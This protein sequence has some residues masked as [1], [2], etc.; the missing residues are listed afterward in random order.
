MLE[1]LESRTLLVA[2]S[3]PISDPTEF[4]A[5]ADFNADGRADAVTTS[6]AAQ[7]L[8]VLLGNGSG[9]F[10]SQTTVQLSV[11]PDHVAAADL[12]GDS[13]LD[14]ITTQFEAG[15]V[16]VMLG[17]GNGSFQSPVYYPAGSGSRAVVPADFDNDGRIDLVTA[18]S[19][20]PTL[21]FLKGNGGG[22]F[23]SPVN[24]ALS[25]I[26][27]DLTAADFNADGKLDLA[28]VDYHKDQLA[29]LYG[30]GNGT[31]QT[32]LLRST[33]AGPASVAAADLNADGRPDLVTSNWLADSFTVVLNSGSSWSSPND[34]ST[35]AGSAPAYIAVADFDADGRADVM[36]ANSGSA[37]VAVF[38]GRNDGTFNPPQNQSL[39][40]A[41]NTNPVPRAIAVADFNANGQPDALITN[42][43]APILSLVSIAA[44][45]PQPEI[46]VLGNG[47]EI[48]D[49]DTTPSAA[50]GTDFGSI[51]QGGA[52]V[53]RTFTVRNDGGAS[54]TLGSLSLPGGYTLI[55]ALAT[56]LAPGAS[57]TFTVRL[58]SGTSG[59]FA[60]DL[61]FATN[62]ANENPFNFRI[63]GSVTAA[64]A[65]SVLWSAYNVDARPMSLRFAFSTDVSASLSSSDLVLRNLT[66]GATVS[67]SAIA[68]AYDRSTNIA[69]FTFPGYANGIVPNGDYQATL[70]ASGVTDSS[71]ARLSADAV[72]SF[73]FLNGDATRDRKVNIR[74]LYV[75][76]MNRGQS[77]RVF[78]QGDFNYDGIVNTA[79]HEILVQNWQRTL[80]TTASGL[81][82]AYAFEESSGNSVQDSSGMGNVGTISGATRTTAGKNGAALVFDGVNDWVTIADSSSLDLTTAMTLQAWVLPTSSTGKQDV[83]I[84]EGVGTEMY[85]L[86][87][88]SDN[89][90]PE[91]N[92]HVNGAN[93]M[94][95]G[96]ALPLNTWSHLAATYDGATLRLF[97]NGALSA[98]LAVA[99]TITTS[100]GAL[101]IGGNSLWGEF[102]AGRID[103]VRIYNRALSV[104]EIQ[105]D[106]NSPV[107]SPAALQTMATDFTAA[108]PE[109]PTRPDLQPS[110]LFSSIGIF[111]D[112]AP[113][114]DNLLP[115]SS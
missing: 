62:D 61:S 100:D 35:G 21:T 64:A 22:G 37:S 93:R 99:G 88:R 82:A 80:N 65:P 46:T 34:V 58:A 49:G 7:K 72:Q 12:N 89:G 57:D 17:N 78:T 63:S 41:I 33:G 70:V 15:T 109:L 27:T 92:V 91:A 10:A 39:I 29:V 2:T 103:D 97:V 14:L 40:D 111:S 59:T 94:A 112:D 38:T 4:V 8:H 66:T 45:N 115:E 52:N 69:T 77:P 102:F 24:T 25:I 85:N 20:Q 104:S 74:D 53:D 18:K 47:I 101:R 3:V 55:E 32:P 114:T 67:S 110:R 5:T 105:A 13:K 86:Y 30:N 11:S 26:P 87:A 98:S 107:P 54:L 106:M 42:E 19:Y 56:T 48:A 36:T 9:G 23:A 90:G 75:Y 108:P 83:I 51:L 84:K 50:D 6:Y 79:D 44:T 81:V 43:A 96:A 60:G 16:G 28:A 95:E 1:H 113:T 71:G 68:V 73:F 76:T 31:F